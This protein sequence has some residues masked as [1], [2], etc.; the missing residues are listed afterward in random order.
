VSDEVDALDP[1][2]EDPDG[3][4]EPPELDEVPVV[5]PDPLGV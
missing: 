4:D 3:D 2:E 1:P 5:V